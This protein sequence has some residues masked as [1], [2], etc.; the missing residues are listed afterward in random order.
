RDIRAAITSWFKVLRESGLKE[1]KTIL[2]DKDFA[3]ISSGM[4]VWKDVEIQL[5]KWHLKRAIEQKLSSKF[6]NIS[7]NYNAINAHQQCPIIDSTWQPTQ[8]SNLG[9]KK[10]LC[11]VQMKS[12]IEQL[13]KF[14]NIV[15]NAT[16]FMY[17]VIC[18]WNGT[19]GISNWRILKRDF[20]YKFNRP[21]LDILCY[22]ITNRMLPKLMHRYDLLVAE[23]IRP[24]WQKDFANEWKRLASR[25]IKNSNKYLTDY[26]HWICS[27]PMF[28]KNRFALCKHLVSPLGNM[29]HSFFNKVQ[30]N[31]KYPFLYEAKQTIWQ[32]IKN[33]LPI[34]LAN[35]E[36]E[37][38]DYEE[39]EVD[40][41]MDEYESGA[42]DVEVT[43][44]KAIE[45]KQILVKAITFIE[46]SETLPQRRKWLNAIEK[47]LDPIKKMVNDLEG[48]EAAKTSRKTWNGRNS[49][50]FYWQ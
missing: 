44:D 28:L 15:I 6:N 37:H 4:A 10:N 11:Q 25:E 43:N 18:G 29:E 39:T 47:N 36:M 19:G 1:V 46:K 8:S 38:C 22:V 14:F 45:L 21:R 2:S 3:Q 23:R 42:S 7:S 9:S 40:L 12:G 16:C 48:F 31:N 50:T 33:G 17:G 20:L 35:S 5:C 41:S 34:A 13:M 30:R 32:D 49:N 24:S 26:T 27:C